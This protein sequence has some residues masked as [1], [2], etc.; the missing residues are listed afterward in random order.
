[1]RSLVLLFL[2]GSTLV[3]CSKKI[4]IEELNRVDEVSIMSVMQAQE[5]A[6]N[7]ADLDAFMEGYWKSESLTFIGSRGLTYGWDTTLENYKRSYPDKTVMG[8]LKFDIISLNRLG[9]KAYHMIGK[10]TLLREEDK[11][12]G[13]FTL[14]WEKINGEWK[15][16]SDQSS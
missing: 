11:P 13:Y 8:T 16:T 4:N 9:D 15:I 3:A 6:W 2:L 5:D 14:I 7:R 1:M 12:S 10:Y